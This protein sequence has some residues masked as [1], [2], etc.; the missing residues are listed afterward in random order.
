MAQALSP[1]T[2]RLT[3]PEQW[4]I[5]PVFHVD[6]L[7]PYKETTFHGS[8][9]TKPPPDLINDEEEYEVEQILDSRVRGRSR[10][11]QYLVKWIGYP[12][13]DNQWLDAEQLTADEAIRE[14]KKKRPHA[15]THIRRVKTGN[16]LIDFSPMSS[17]TP[18][19]IE[20]V[21]RSGA[22]SPHEYSLAAPLNATDLEQVLEQ[23]P[24]PTQPPDSDD[25]L[26]APEP[27]TGGLDVDE[28]VVVRTV[29][30]SELQPYSVSLAG[31]SPMREDNA[32]VC[33]SCT[34]EGP[35]CAELDQ[36]RCAVCRSFCKEP[37]GPS[38]RCFC[39]QEAEAEA[40]PKYVPSGDETIH[41]MGAVYPHPGG[42]TPGPR[43]SRL[44]WEKTGPEEE[45]DDEDTSDDDDYQHDKNP[46]PVPT[47]GC[48]APM[49]E[50]VGRGWTATNQK[51]STRTPRQASPTP[52]G[53][54]LNI[55]P[56]YIPFKLVD[57]KTGRQIPAKYVQLF[58]NNDDPYAYGKMSSTGPTFI[59]KIQ[60]A[61]DTDSWE[62]PS[63]AT[64][65]TQYF[66]AKYH[67]RAE[68]DAAVSRLC[69]P[70]LQAEVRRYRAARYQH[71][72]IARKID[73]LEGELFATGMKKCASLRRLM[74]AN[75]KACIEAKRDEEG[76]VRVALPWEHVRNTLHV[77][78]LDD[79]L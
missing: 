63:Y 78:D 64:E 49:N 72:M 5:H 62:K 21:I 2:Y 10:K 73:R 29:T 55:H 27:I 6:L 36:P 7:T 76:F 35:H 61:P 19:T 38:N 46:F 11:V 79:G 45:E 8:N 1:V 12:S 37:G 41:N 51:P 20:N 71:R 18:S 74:A 17:P 66:D 54:V 15:V 60:A 4:K 39:R 26:A 31:S 47:V 48:P 44:Y 59:A 69:D 32:E 58:L 14:F 65:D 25:S 13:S 77:D 22:S 67:D 52:P 33:L 3:L 16:P 56:N 53:F 40:A 70:S 28:P 9:Y 43:V 23:F 75:A 30:P 34:P 24:D 42:T 68:V 57:D 50:G